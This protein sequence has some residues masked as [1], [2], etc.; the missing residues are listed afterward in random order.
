MLKSKLRKTGVCRH[1]RTQSLENACY[2]STTRPT[3]STLF[4]Q[5]V[6]DCP[7]EALSFLP[8]FAGFYSIYYIQAVAK[9]HFLQIKN[10]YSADGKAPCPPVGRRVKRARIPVT[11]RQRIHAK[12]PR[13]RGEKQRFYTHILPP[14]PAAS[15]ACFR[16]FFALFSSLL[17]I[18]QVSRRTD[19]FANADAPCDGKGRTGVSAQ[20]K[21]LHGRE[22]QVR[23]R[24]SENLTFPKRRK[25][26][27]FA[28]LVLVLFSGTRCSGC[29][30]F[31]VKHL[32][33]CNAGIRT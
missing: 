7:P 12:F 4:L 5:N 31:H 8:R 27:G 33:A 30:T 19:V 3:L 22:A 21:T 29:G 6:P 14:F 20:F 1:L 24:Q 18:E 25:P 23:R 17:Y 9:T 2:S 11:D 15:D 16:M 10:F 32:R 26:H 28:C 13:F